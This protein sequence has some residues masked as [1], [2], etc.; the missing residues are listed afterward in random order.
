MVI[1]DIP[2]A[3]PA[4]CENRNAGISNLLEI[5]GVNQTLVENFASRNLLTPVSGSFWLAA[6]HGNSVELL[7]VL[8]S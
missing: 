6:C 5:K 1:I 8:G 7:V 3:K 2:I 4:E